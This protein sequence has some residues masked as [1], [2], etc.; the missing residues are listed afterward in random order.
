[1]N[2]TLE[3]TPKMQKEPLDRNTLVITVDGSTTAGK[4]VVA[5]R[6]AQRYN[7]TVFNTG[8][9]IRALALLAIENNMV[10]TDQTNVTTIP[11]DFTERIVEFY[12]TMPQKLTIAKP[13]EGEHTARIMVGDREMRGELLAYGK[14]KAVDN[15]SG[16]IAASPLV[17]DK[18]YHVWRES[19]RDLGGTIVIGR[20]TGIDLYPDAPIKLYLFAS[21]E[22]SAAY[23]VTHDPTSLMH[24]ST[25]ELYIRERDGKDRINGLLDRPGDA[26]AIDT[27][28]YISQDGKGMSALESR[29]AS[30]IDNRFIIK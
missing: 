26:L 15:L 24:Q 18:L 19:V 3:R 25:E 8:T 12:N 6:L 1:M 4:R 11:V 27:S 17:R 5:E 22:A 16:V 2:A 28:T 30:F 9:T 20:K 14:Q 21:P 23:R 29:I 7:L 10:G 13:R